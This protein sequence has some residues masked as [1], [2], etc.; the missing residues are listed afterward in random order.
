MRGD[1]SIYLPEG[2]KLVLTARVETLNKTK[3]SWCVQTHVIIS[4]SLHNF[5]FS[6]LFSLNALFYQLSRRSVSPHNLALTFPLGSS[7]PIFILRGH[8]TGGSR[9]R[10]HVASST[11]TGAMGSAVA[12]I[13][14]NRPP[15]GGSC[16]VCLEGTGTIGDDD[17]V[18]CVTTGMPLVDVFR[19]ECQVGFVYLPACTQLLNVC[20][21]DGRHH[22]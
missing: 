4:L 14:S 22:A 2:G 1:G 12:E 8:I 11:Q 18:E 19:A 6:F 9:L 21:M 17:R 16:T 15:S 5:I 10:V 7:G 13:F 20:P 3:Y